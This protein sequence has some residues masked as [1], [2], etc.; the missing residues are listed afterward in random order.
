MPKLKVGDIVVWN[1]I[2]VDSEFFSESDL[3]KFNISDLVLILEIVNNICLVLAIY[4]NTFHYAFS[5]YLHK[6][7]V[8]KGV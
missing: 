8:Y 3:E 6:L 5:S 7:T 2:S 4:D 1:F